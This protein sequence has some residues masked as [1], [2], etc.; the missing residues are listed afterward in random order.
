MYR[1]SNTILRKG[2]I[3]SFGNICVFDKT[4]IIR[5]AFEAVSAFFVILEKY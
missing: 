3:D 2:T 4:Q 5:L 1:N